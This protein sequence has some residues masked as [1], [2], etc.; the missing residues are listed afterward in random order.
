MTQTLI[1]G[2]TG[3]VGP[4][5]VSAL[6]NQHKIRAFTRDA[7]QAKALLPDH[8]EIF[9]GDFSDDHRLREALDSMESMLLLTPHA[10]NM[11]EIQIRIIRLARRTGIRI[12]KISGTSS[13]IRPDGPDACR[14]HWEV[15]RVLTESGQPHVILRPNA[16]MQTL[17]GQIMASAVRTSGVIPNA[18]GSAGIS[19]VDCRDIGEV[20]AAALTD[21]AHEGQRYVLTGPQSV[22][23]RQVA[24]EVSKVT[25]REV[26]TSEITP[27]DIKRAFLQRG[28]EPWEA[29]HFEEMYQLFRSGESEYVT[30]DIA[31]VTGHRPRTV[32]EYIA[33]HRHLFEPELT[34]NAVE[35]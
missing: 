6:G 8:V 23:Y 33:T 12:V 15:E 2:A 7:A 14:Q 13:A 34:S 1:I 19:V 30:D 26:Q 20:A 27:A 32:E 25:G 21:P 9:E 31:R 11:G 4:H 16:F 18:I 29:E 5:V 17:L 3:T 10:G 24:D 28:T 35:D 22:T